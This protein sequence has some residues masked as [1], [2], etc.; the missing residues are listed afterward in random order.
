MIIHTILEASGNSKP[1]LWI[2]ITAI[3]EDLLNSS[4]TSR[5]AACG[6]EVEE[7][8]NGTDTLPAVVEEVVVVV[9]V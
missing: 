2:S 9:K 7:H 8:W 1:A 4:V 3:E 6:W 5:E